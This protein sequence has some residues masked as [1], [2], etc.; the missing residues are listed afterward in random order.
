[1]CFT[2]KDLVCSALNLQYVEIF[3]RDKYQ[4]ANCDEY[5]L[6][7]VFLDLIVDSF[8]FPECDT[9]QI[10]AVESA[11]DLADMVEAARYDI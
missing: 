8:A 11:Q 10:W 2:V 5:E 7:G 9:L 1:M 4:I 3:T 6:G